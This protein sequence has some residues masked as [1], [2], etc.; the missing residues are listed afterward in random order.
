MNF[1]L[2]HVEFRG[3]E[4]DVLEYEESPIPQWLHIHESDLRPLRT[5][6]PRHRRI[7]TVE[8]TR[9]LRYRKHPFFNQF[10]IVASYYHPEDGFDGI[11]VPSPPYTPSRYSHYKE[12]EKTHTLSLFYERKMERST[13][14]LRQFK[15]IAKKLIGTLCTRQDY[16]KEDDPPIEHY[17]YRLVVEK[18]IHRHYWS[19]ALASCYMTDTYPL[20]IGCPN[21]YEYFPEES[22]TPIDMSDIQHALDRITAIARSDM[23]QTRKKALAVARQRLVHQHNLYT[24]ISHM[25]Q[26]FAFTL[27]ERKDDTCPAIVIS[28]E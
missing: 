27:L 15:R 23:W 4:G 28:T 21:L 25:V 26:E 22:Y 19:N 3:F 14:S 18:S 17:R 24:S 2:N 7:F 8:E 16:S 10:G 11:W 13:D 1:V 5:T 6:F 20:Y 12:V 9:V